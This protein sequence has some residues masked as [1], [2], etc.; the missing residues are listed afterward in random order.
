MQSE[1][2]KEAN[3]KR[4]QEVQARLQEQQRVVEERVKEEVLRQHSQMSM[5]V[6]KQRELE[7]NRRREGRESEE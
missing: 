5:T 1:T 3:K 6:E 7:A 4:M 2:L